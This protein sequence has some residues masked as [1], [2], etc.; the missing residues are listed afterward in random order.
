M[1]VHVV[2][3]KGARD[4]YVPLGGRSAGTAA[5]LLA[6]LPAAPVAVRPARGPAASPACATGPTHVLPRQRRR[7]Y[8]QGGRHS[9]PEALFRVQGNAE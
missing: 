1:C 9:H 2:Q 3:G 5:P 8:H 4:R 6:D 7:R